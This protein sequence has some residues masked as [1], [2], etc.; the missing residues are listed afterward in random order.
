MYEI[1]DNA[2][3]DADGYIEYILFYTPVVKLTLYFLLVFHFEC[4]QEQQNL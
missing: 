4:S 3:S 1:I 2:L